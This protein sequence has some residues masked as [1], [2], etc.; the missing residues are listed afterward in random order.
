MK[1]YNDFI[2]KL[3]NREHDKRSIPILNQSGTPET[4][5]WLLEKAQSIPDQVAIEWLVGAMVQIAGRLETRHD[6][7]F[8][9]VDNVEPQ[10]RIVLRQLRSLTLREM[11]ASFPWPT[12]EMGGAEVLPVRSM[13][14]EEKQKWMQQLFKLLRDDKDPQHAKKPPKVKVDGEAAIPVAARF[15]APRQQKKPSE[16]RNS[17]QPQLDAGLRRSAATRSVRAPATASMSRLSLED[18]DSR[19]RSPAPTFKPAYENGLSVPENGAFG[20]R[21]REPSPGPGD[22]VGLVRLMST[23]RRPGKAVLSHALSLALFRVD[24]M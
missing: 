10:I 8:P 2:M 9:P 18:A 13:K 6:W 3:Q 23:N 11:A 24:E 16:N 12:R 14:P 20:S 1:E 19:G 22:D 7:A 15:E 4:L 17:L 21:S 5:G